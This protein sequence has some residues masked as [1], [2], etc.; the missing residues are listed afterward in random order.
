MD[1]TLHLSPDIESSLLERARSRGIALDDYLQEIVTKEL[2]LAPAEAQQARH[3]DN[4]SDLLLS[5][6]F[7]AACLDLQRSNDYPRPIDLPT[8]GG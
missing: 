6:P 4:L 2:G 7:A 5:S 8:N 3:F 1:V